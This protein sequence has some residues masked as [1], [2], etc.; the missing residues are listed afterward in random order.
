MLY[1]SASIIA[2]IFQE[3]PA[4]HLFAVEKM[5]TDLF[6]FVKKR[7]LITVTQNSSG[8]KCRTIDLVIFSSLSC[9]RT[10]W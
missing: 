10:L 2:K 3:T 6:I 7:K 5:N 8:P 1:L 9:Y 4:G